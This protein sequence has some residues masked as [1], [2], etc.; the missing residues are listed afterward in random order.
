MEHF[1]PSEMLTKV[2]IAFLP[3]L[4]LCACQTTGLENTQELNPAGG[5]RLDWTVQPESGDIILQIQANAVG[6]V[7]LSIDNADKT[8]SDA[9]LGGFDATL[10]L[11]YVYVR[12][13]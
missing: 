9:I 2:M 10:G 1:C 5:F 6:W 13:K 3:L 11:P 8:L 7:F 12:I 4:A